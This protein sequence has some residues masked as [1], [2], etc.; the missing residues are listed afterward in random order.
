V[1]QIFLIDRTGPNQRAALLRAILF[2]A[3]AAITLFDWFVIRPRIIDSRQRYIEH[4]DEPEIANP[5]K[6]QF[7]RDHKLSVS[8]LM[9]VLGILLLLIAY[10]SNIAPKKDE[11]V[12]RFSMVE[13]IAFEFEEARA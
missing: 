3:A 7:D 13:D 8:L 12:I 1:A 2:L 11:K 4:A 10:S 5:A 9:F 6:D